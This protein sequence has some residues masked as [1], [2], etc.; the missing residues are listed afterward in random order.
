LLPADDADDLAERYAARIEKDFARSPLVRF[1]QK[2][3][4]FTLHYRL[5]VATGSLSA[6]FP[7][8]RMET[9][10]VLHASDLLKWSDWGPLARGYIESAGDDIP[11]GEAF[12]E[13][14][15][16]AVAF[17]EWFRDALWTRHRTKL[18]ELEDAEAKVREFQRRAWGEP[19][20]GPR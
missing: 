19:I 12:G 3:R 6:G 10:V 18:T 11:V 2:L 8:M 7:E 16:V 20:S 9:R 13:Y 4:N 5:P 1:V 14:A 17:H 15:A